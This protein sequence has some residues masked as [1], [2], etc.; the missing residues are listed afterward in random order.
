MEV[1]SHAYVAYDRKYIIK[2]ELKKIRKKVG[3]IS[4]KLN[5]LSISLK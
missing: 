4:S 5:S 2:D 1:L 3:M